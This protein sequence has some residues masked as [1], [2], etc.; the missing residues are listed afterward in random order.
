MTIC[1]RCGCE[2]PC[3]CDNYTPASQD[4]CVRC[5]CTKPCSCDNYSNRQEV[6]LNAT[7]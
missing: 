3:G 4:V 2:K 7:D 6:A 1:Q 5:G